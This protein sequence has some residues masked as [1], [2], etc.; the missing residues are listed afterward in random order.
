MRRIAVL[1]FAVLAVQM[2]FA[3]VDTG[4]ITGTVLDTQGAGVPSASLTFV[5]TSTSATSK[6]QTDASG[7]Y[8]SPPLKPGTYK[9]TAQASGFKVQTHEAVSVRVQ[10]RL[11]LDFNMAVGSVTENVL[12]T[13]ETPSIQTDT[14]S[15]GEVITTTQITQLPLNGRDY[16]QLATLTTG[17]VRTSSGTNGNSG[18]SSTGGLNSFVANGTRGTLNN[19]LL[20]GIDNN[21]NDNGGVVL[22]SNVDAIQEFKLQTNSYS[23]EFGRSGGAVVNAITKSGANN[24]HGDVFEFFRN[25]SLDARDF[26]EDPTQKKASFKQNQFGATFGGPIV[27]NKLFWFIDYQGTRIRNPQTFVSAIPTLEERVGNFSAP[28]EPIIYD[29][30]THIPFAGNIIPPGRID[31]T[32]QAYANLYPIPQSGQGNNF[33]ISPTERDRVDQGDVRLDYNFSQSDQIFV[34]YSK[35]GRT[36]IRPAPLPGLANGGNSSTGVGN[37]DTDGAAIGFT[38]TFTP[39][40]INELRVG[41]SYVHIRRGVPESGN[42]LPPPELRIPGVPD[43]PRV[44]GLTL[45]APNGFRRLGDPNF[46]PT[47]LASQ[48]RQITDVLT[49]V[50]GGHTLKLGGEIR[51]SQFNISQEASPRGRFSFSGEFTQAA[52]GSGGS[53]IADMLL[54][55][56]ISANISTVIGM[57]NRQ[58]VPSLFVQDDWKVNRRLTLNLGLRY[59]YFSPIVEAHDRQSN[60]NYATGTLVVA[61]Q[62]GASR[63]LTVADKANF[64][65]RIGFAWTPRESADLVVRGAY[66]IFYSGQEIR[67]AAPL[68]LAY[69]LPF[70][71][72]P[73]F[74][75]SGTTPVITVA[76]GFPPLNPNQAINPGVTS[77]DPRLHTPYYQSWNLAVQQSLPAAISLELAYAGSKGTHLQ[78][79][80]DP[81]Q[82]PVPR[83]GDVDVQSLRPFPQF[84]PFTAIQN[85]GSSIYHSMQ[86][87]GEKHLSHGLYFLSAFTWS[88]AINDL[89]EICCNFPFP[90]NSYDV[91][92][93]RARADFDQKLRWVFS[94]DYELPFGGS[95]SHINNRVLDAV[96]G[97]WHVGGIYTL[98]SGFPF[99]AAVGFDPSNTGSQGLMRADQIRDGNLPSD[100]RSP[101]QW[102]D[103]NAFTPPADGTFGNAHRNNLIGPGQNV[104]DGSLR[105]VFAVTESQRLE[106]R[107]EFFNMFNHPNFAQPDNF[108][109][110]G[111]G[112]AGTITE[113]AIPMRQIQFGLKYSF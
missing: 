46:A 14:S 113:I 37:E 45:F 25:S 50:R 97:G 40:T 69:N 94:F 66:G 91:G 61:G 76:Q 63:S 67:T 87:K 93:E 49:L 9:V 98:A 95:R 5:E 20:D 36:D 109:D 100:Q 39:K 33:T 53:S 73:S 31:P 29:P 48:E 23:A 8:A 90:Q 72:E 38:H 92:A 88:K 86:I 35:S 55:L 7:N 34:R 58:H 47:I 60:F 74:V 32:A 68:Q 71:Y 78:S 110:D 80:T 18:G 112:V 44:N 41:F 27:K 10:D 85:R 19:F 107:A 77:L 52:D 79:V 96:A 101:N 3:Q 75:S 57:G 59:D 43:D 28:G 15:L 13:A 70:F 26:F 104:F 56:P 2:L 30:I 54:G 6:T 105:K 83:A 99:S 42:Q 82:V 106:F 11:R 62:N 51:W 17:V 103:I 12:V 22:R 81:N 84:G 108:I 21:S 89:P 111:P 16:I 1:C 24:Y 65:P 102:F 64:S 4:T